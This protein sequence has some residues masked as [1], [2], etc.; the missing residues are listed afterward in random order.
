MK[1]IISLILAALLALST[2]TAALAATY[3]DKETVKKVQQALNDA[4]YNCGTPDGIAG[5]KTAAAI[6]QY[7]TDKGLEVSEIIDDALLEAMGIAVEET[8]PD[9]DEAT[10][11]SGVV[12]S[13]ASDASQE[14]DYNDPMT[15][16]MNYNDALLN[17]LQMLGVDVD[18]EDI[19]QSKYLFTKI[20]YSY[21][22]SDKSYMDAS[23]SDM[24][25][26]LYTE[27][28]KQELNFLDHASLYAFLATVG[29]R[30]ECSEE[31]VD[32]LQNLL[33]EAPSRDG[34]I[35]TENLYLE[36]TSDSVELSG[37]GEPGEFY[38]GARKPTIHKEGDDVPEVPEEIVEL[39]GGIP[40]TI[41]G[42][43]GRF[44]LSELDT[45]SEQWDAAAMFADLRV[46][47]S[48]TFP[49]MGHNWTMATI[50]KQG[51]GDEELPLTISN[52]EV[53]AT[54]TDDY[55]ND[56]FDILD[57][58]SDDY[59]VLFAL[60][61]DSEVEKEASIKFEGGTETYYDVELRVTKTEK[62]YSVQLYAG[63]AGGNSM[64]WYADYDEN[65]ALSSIS[66]EEYQN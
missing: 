54:R 1:K 15:L 9:S 37:Y 27:P 51:E 2:L 5:R 59:L 33:G 40:N 46:G 18:N 13:E 39:T 7:R 12:S 38:I 28:E 36:F 25:F 44:P 43:A 56:Y 53:I 48:H 20:S 63:I 55:P 23:G 19:G 66:Y 42:L 10:E 64:R 49:D 61:K 58:Y 26:M 3:T 34:T 4:G 60:E 22:E 11:P 16:L 50:G 29:A 24:V 32:E 57:L 14:A 45:L 17:R 65:G 30:Y 31:D 41:D 35:S 52:G 8:A 6:T 21:M 62:G 47:K